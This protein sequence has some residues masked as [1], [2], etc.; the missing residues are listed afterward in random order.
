M[1]AQC[2]NGRINEMVANIRNHI[3]R[4]GPAHHPPSPAAW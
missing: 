1:Y 4:I 2:R 3:Q